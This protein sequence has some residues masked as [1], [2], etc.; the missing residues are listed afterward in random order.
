[1]VGMYGRKRTNDFQQKGFRGEFLLALADNREA[2]I[3]GNEGIAKGW[4]ESVYELRLRFC[5]DSRR[6]GFEEAEFVPK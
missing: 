5:K 1:M 3:T 2:V 6:K 4:F